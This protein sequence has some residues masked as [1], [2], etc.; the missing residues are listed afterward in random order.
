MTSIRGLTALAFA[1]IAALLSPI[2]TPLNVVIKD[3]STNGL[4]TTRDHVVVNRTSEDSNQNLMHGYT[5]A[6]SDGEITCFD[7]LPVPPVHEVSTKMDV[8]I[9]Y[10]CNEEYN[11]MIG[12]PQI[13]ILATEKQLKPPCGESDLC[14]A[15]SF[16]IP[17]FGNWTGILHF[18]VTVGEGQEALSIVELDARGYGMIQG[19]ILTNATTD[20]SIS[21]DILNPLGVVLDS[22]VD[23]VQV[24]DHTD[25]PRHWIQAAQFAVWDSQAT[26]LY[27]SDATITPQD[28]VCFR[29]YHNETAILNEIRTPG[30]FQVDFARLL[31]GI[32]L[33]P[34][35]VRIGPS[36][37]NLSEE[38]QMVE[39]P[40]GS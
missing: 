39:V 21:L 8:E 18:S 5:A 35:F 40:L 1:V 38:A 11:S 12:V 19:Q 9:W 26:Y 27:A 6:A 37:G 2:A 14:Q 36:C 25:V 13:G 24:V 20:Y 33:T 34:S 15:G 22:A 29:V 16:L 17:T 23:S 31:G 4:E 28:T 10:T 7:F 30:G 32:D 3:G